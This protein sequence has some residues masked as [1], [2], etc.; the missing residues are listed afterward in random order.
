[1]KVKVRQELK[2]IDKAELVKK[3]TDA[4]KALAKAN[5]DHK[6]FKLKN[7]SSLMSMRQEIAV[8]L[9]ILREKELSSHKEGKI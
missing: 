6:Q 5:L 4:R 8:I 3:L 1:M 7:T 2:T 9:T